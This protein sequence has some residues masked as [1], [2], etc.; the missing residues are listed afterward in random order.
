MAG[1]SGREAVVAVGERT[2]TGVEIISG[3]APALSVTARV[4]RGVKVRF[5]FDTAAG[6][7]GRRGA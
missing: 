3:S 7:V 5:L 1:S 6:G 4:A 2:V